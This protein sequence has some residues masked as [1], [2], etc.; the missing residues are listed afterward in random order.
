MPSIDWLAVY[1]VRQGHA[2]PQREKETVFFTKA[3]IYQEQN[4]KMQITTKNLS[5]WLDNELDVNCW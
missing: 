5:L 3:P 2:L 4:L 1:L